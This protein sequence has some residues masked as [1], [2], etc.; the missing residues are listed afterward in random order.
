MCETELWLVLASTLYITVSQRVT[1]VKSSCAV[2]SVDVA[3]S[4]T[5]PTPTNRVTTVKSSC[6]VDSV[7][8]VLSPT[9][10]TPTNNWNLL[11]S[12]RHRC[13]GN[14]CLATNTIS[15]I[16]VKTVALITSDILTTIIQIPYRLFESYIHHVA[17]VNTTSKNGGKFCNFC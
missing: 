14:R 11:T 2:D 6:A 12:T 5:L 1:T 4:P 10:P 3:L 8:V 9:L 13:H 7:D 15:N 16:R 17:T